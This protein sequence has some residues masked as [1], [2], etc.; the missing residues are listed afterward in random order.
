MSSCVRPNEDNNADDNHVEV[1]SKDVEGKGDSE[2]I[3]KDVLVAD[4]VDEDVNDDLFADAVE[5]DEEREKAGAQG[6]IE[7]IPE[8]EAEDLLPRRSSPDPGRPT[9]EEIDEHMIDHLPF[10]SWCEECVK[11]RGTGE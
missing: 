1:V 5:P 9:Q 11:G 6:E 10:R 4:G 8:D 7:E 3:N 2:G